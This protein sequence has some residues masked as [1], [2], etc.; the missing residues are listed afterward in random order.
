MVKSVLEPLLF[1]KDT[2]DFLLSLVFKRN[3]QGYLVIFVTK[4]CEN[5]V[6]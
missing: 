5:L 2:K 6:S 3:I 1:K 4:L